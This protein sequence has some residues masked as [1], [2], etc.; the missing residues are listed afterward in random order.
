MV[1]AIHSFGKESEF[2]CI[3]LSLYCPH[4]ATKK[5][6]RL[7]RYSHPL[8]RNRSHGSI[9]TQ[10]PISQMICTEEERAI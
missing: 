9:G 7:C 10:I 4:D 5:E 1:I 8:L 3:H 6:S 2:K